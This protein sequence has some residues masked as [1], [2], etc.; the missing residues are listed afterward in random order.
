MS[1]S[2]TDM[3]I[4]TM[5]DCTYKYLRFDSPSKAPSSNSPMLLL[6]SNLKT[7]CQNIS[8]DV[9]IDT[10]LLYTKHK[11]TNIASYLS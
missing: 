2:V 1:K 7:Q 11:P 3:Y 9:S 4:V 5:L 6:L 10:N 8:K